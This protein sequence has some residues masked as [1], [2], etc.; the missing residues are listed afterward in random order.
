MITSAAQW[1][2]DIAGTVTRSIG[3]SWTGEHLLDW[4]GSNSNRRYYGTNA[5]HDVTWTADST[6]AIG[7]SLRFDPWGTPRSAVPSGYVPFRFQGSWHDAT[8]DLAWVVTRW[9]AP[10][11]G[12][13]ISEDTLLGQP[14][15]PGSRHLYAYGEGDPVGT[16][17]PDGMRWRLLGKTSEFVDSDPEK[18]WWDNLSIVGCLLLG[19]GVGIATLEL[20]PPA[21]L[22]IGTAAGGAC[23]VTAK[24]ATTLAFNARGLNIQKT[25]ETT[26]LKNDEAKTVKTIWADTTTTTRKTDPRHPEVKFQVVKERWYHFARNYYYDDCVKTWNEG[27][28]LGGTTC[29]R[30]TNV[31]IVRTLRDDIQR[32]YWTQQVKYQCRYSGGFQTKACT[33]DPSDTRRYS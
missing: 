33:W 21:A 15:N 26:W 1:I 32:G 2:D 27:W 25:R 19:V 11:L 30:G 5:H 31:E 24:V 9:Y 3:N 17:D 29:R 8:T 16:W 28:R 22:A 18:D 13:F 6:G 4:T 10:S 14:I 12:R 23:S 7:Q 20:T